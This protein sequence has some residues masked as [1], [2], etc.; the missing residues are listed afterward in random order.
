MAPRGV[1]KTGHS[2]SKSAPV[3][4][5]GGEVGSIKIVR[6]QREDGPASAVPSP[7]VRFR[8]IVSGTLALICVLWSCGN[9]GDDGQATAT[10]ASV[11]QE[12]CLVFLHGK[13][14]TGKETVITDGVSVIS[15][16][17]NDALGGEARQWLYFSDEEYEQA[18]SIVRQATAGCESV[19]VNGFSNGGAFAAK[20][21][22]RG[23]DL[24][25]R[26]LR[27]VVDD[28]VVDQGVL[29]CTPNPA[30]DVALYWTGALAEDAQPDRDCDELGW[31]CE[32]GVLIGVDAYADE[33]ETP[34]LSSIHDEHVP[35]D[36]A[37]E[38]SQ[39]T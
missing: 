20:F 9:E 30:V 7:E 37:P 5:I 34:V 19:I 3:V 38:L 21:Y 1:G 14:D 28:P 18:A 36:T 15:P 27:V 26:L 16:S 17:G 33:L 8:A 11:P 10:T 4:D 13:G 2:A 12:R 25:G 39:W 35:Y 29:G 31:T 32:G 22:C 23:E 24:D 6:W